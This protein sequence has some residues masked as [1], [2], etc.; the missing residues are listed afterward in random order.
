M[1]FLLRYELV[2][3]SLKS[4]K[5]Y[6]LFRSINRPCGPG[7]PTLGGSSATDPGGP[8]GPK[9]TRVYDFLKPTSPLVHI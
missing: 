2:L 3:V 9:M 7:A 4:N 5:N 8:G 6:G 1:Q